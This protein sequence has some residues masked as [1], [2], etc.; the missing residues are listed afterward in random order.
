MATK[1]KVE[2]CIPCYGNQ[3]PQWWNRIMMNIL[4]DIPGVDI[5]RV[6]SAATMLSDHNKNTLVGKRR[7][8]ATDAARNN[9]TN[10]FLEDVA[11]SVFFIDDDTIPPRGALGYLVRLQREFASGLYFLPKPPYHPIAYMRNKDGLYAAINR[12]SPG[13]MFPVDAVGMGCAL[14]HRS[15]FE[16]IAKEHV[17]FKRQDGSIYPIHKDRVNN[18]LD[19]SGKEKQPWLEDGILHTPGR[20]M[21]QKEIDLAPFP[22]F[23]LD[24]QRTEDFAF[25]E[26]AASVGVVPWLDTTIVCEHIKMQAKGVDDFR[27]HEKENQE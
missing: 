4:D 11:D 26:L 18:E 16:K 8:T 1:V 23:N 12:F 22:Y 3:S 14:I 6:T 19:Y 15:V 21:D 2:I 7:D 5:I 10:G 9:L 17:V 20:I 25:C 24:S 27:Q 13:S